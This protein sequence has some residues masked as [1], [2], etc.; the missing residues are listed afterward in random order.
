M[1]PTKLDQ[2][3]TLYRMP[4]VHTPNLVYRPERQNVTLRFTNVSLGPT[5]YRF[6]KL[7]T[8][9]RTRLRDV[10]VGCLNENKLGV[11]SMKRSIVD[12][13]PGRK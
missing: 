4:G 2:V 3:R 10:M 11:A 8:E 9:Q 13:L 5:L 12:V 1:E 7:D 6:S